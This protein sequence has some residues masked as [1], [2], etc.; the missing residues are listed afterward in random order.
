MVIAKCA[1]CGKEYELKANDKLSDFQCECGGEL[2]SNEM[3]SATLKTKKPNKTP[4]DI[5]EDWDK[6]SKNKKIGIGILGVCC[7]GII[8]IVVF[9]G[10]FSPNKTTS[11]G[12]SFQNQ[13]ISF[14]KPSDLTV[15]DNSTS[16]QL[17]VILLDGSNIVGEIQ[18]NGMN[19]SSYS[20]AVS[21]G[22]SITVAG[23]PTIETSDSD[24]LDA[25][26]TY[27]NS[28]GYRLVM[29]INFDPS[30]SAD[31]NIVKNSLTIKQSPPTP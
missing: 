16:S 6:Q 3:T 31:Y 11:S 26:I 21:G 10:L 17:D 1:K 25:W 27:G 30:N 14:T 12:N 29:D 15:T 13:Y 28:Q 7:I 9:G 19:P 8:L 23:K 5:R 2:T 18:S 4:K 22:K 20:A 24:N